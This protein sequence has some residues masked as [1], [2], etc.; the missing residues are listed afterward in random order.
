MLLYNLKM[1]YYKELGVS[2]DSTQEEIKKAF[3]K[4][5]LKHHPDK[6]TGNEEKFKKI[7]EAF[8]TLGDENKR[9][10]YDFQQSGGNMPQGMPFP[11]NMRGMGIPP[12]VFQSMFAGGRM[13]QGMPGFFNF[14]Q[15]MGGMNGANVRI[16]RN[17]VEQT[18]PMSKPVPI[19]KSVEISLEQ[20]YTGIKIPFELERW[21]VEGEMKRVEKETIYIDIPE[22]TDNNEILFIREKGNIISDTNKGDVKV[23]IKVN[24]ET[25]FERNGLNLILKKKISLKEALCGFDFLIKYFGGRK[26]TIKNEDNIITPGFSKVVPGLDLKRGEHTGNLIITFDI[27]FPEKLDKEKVEKLKELL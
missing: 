9:K 2:K 8:Q 27:E 10:E 22:G 14:S 5:S 21:V 26:F 7:N 12:E 25:E 3:R 11:G 19:I 1:S 13:P 23:F 17:G 6:P 18:N 20:A 4:L 15:H 16:F 24:N